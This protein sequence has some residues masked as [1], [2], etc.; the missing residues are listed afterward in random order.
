M[1][2]YFRGRSGFS[3]NEGTPPLPGSSAEAT[4]STIFPEPGIPPRAGVP[5]RTPASPRD[6][7]STQERALGLAD[8]EEQPKLREELAGVR[9]GYRE[10][11]GPHPPRGGEA[12]DREAA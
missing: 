9:T 11:S 6:Q 3:G 10:R 2:K 4:S 5:R 12:N 7:A 8:S 1:K